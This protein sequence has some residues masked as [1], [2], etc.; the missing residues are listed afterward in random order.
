MTQQELG[1]SAAEAMA[2]VMAVPPQQGAAC[3]GAGRGHSH[4]PPPS[5]VCFPRGGITHC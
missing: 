5:P 1:A 2:L 4:A 3:R